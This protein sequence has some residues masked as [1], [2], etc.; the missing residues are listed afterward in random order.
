MAMNEI[1]K[2]QVTNIPPGTSIRGKFKGNLYQIS[3]KLGEGAI[4]TVYLCHHE[5][6]AAALKIS[7]KQTSMT[8]E[9]NGLKALE[10]VRKN[11]LGPALLD[12]DDWV[13]PNGRTF[14]FYVM[15]YVKGETVQEFFQKNGTSWIGPFMLQLLD[16]LEHLHGAGWVFGD[17][18]TENLII[19]NQPPRIRWVDVG[20]MT[21]IGRSIKEY[22]EF[23]D[24]GYWGLGSRRAEPSYDLFSF[25]MIF[26]EI[27]YPKRFSRPEKGK[28]KYLLKRIDQVKALR[29]Y[30]PILKKAIMGRYRTSGEMKNELL[31][32]LS[33]TQQVNPTKSTPSKE[34]SSLFEA[35]W[36]FLFSLLSFLFSLFIG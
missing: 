36:I 22:T 31:K 3:R 30:A 32:K 8:L 27:F 11:Q 16:D 19:S 20:G 14:S 6:Q 21:Q 29:P 10:Q 5:R 33:A 12:V 2:K 4:G 18:K 23:Y 13:A 35:I 7:E 28:G 34:R 24:R 17:L 26:L 25:V 15:E 1:W 9:V